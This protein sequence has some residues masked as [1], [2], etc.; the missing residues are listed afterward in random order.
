MHGSWESVLHS[1][2]NPLAPTV[3]E[4]L[5]RA[6]T[7]EERRTFEAHLRPLVDAGQGATRSAAA[8]L[9]ALKPDQ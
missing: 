5:E 6:L 2:G 3:A 8:F 7:P 9:R 1:S 4:A